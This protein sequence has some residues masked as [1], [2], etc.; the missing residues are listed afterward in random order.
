MERYDRW[1]ENVQY[2]QFDTPQGYAY[3][4]HEVDEKFAGVRSINQSIIINLIWR[5]LTMLTGASQ[6]CSVRPNYNII[7]NS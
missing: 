2:I 4:L 6:Y 5:Q 3:N 7:H 1:P